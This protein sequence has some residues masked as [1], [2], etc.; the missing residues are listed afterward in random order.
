MHP[1]ALQVR[2]QVSSSSKA[3][4]WD[5]QWL[6]DL[7]RAKECCDF[8]VRGLK[9]VALIFRDF[10]QRVVYTKYQYYGR[11][12]ARF[13]PSPPLPWLAF[14]ALTTE[15]CSSLICQSICWKGEAH[16]TS[17]VELSR[18]SPSQFQVLLGRTQQQAG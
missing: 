16:L 9:R 14:R 1:P 6:Q 10:A 18:V 11:A 5:H 17:M 15:W 7:S 8:H 12:S 4:L 2:S 13:E 3:A